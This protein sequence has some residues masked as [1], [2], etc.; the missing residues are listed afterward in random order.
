MTLTPAAN[1]VWNALALHHGDHPSIPEL[2]AMVGVTERTVQR[3]IS[4]LCEAGV[5]AVVARPGSVNEYVL[6]GVT[7]GGD[8]LNVRGDI[9]GDICPSE[10]PLPPA[11]TVLFTSTFLPLPSTSRE[12]A[13]LENQAVQ[14][15]DRLVT[16][17]HIHYRSYRK[18]QFELYP[19]ARTVWL[20]T[21]S[22]MLADDGRQLDEILTVLDYAFAQP[23]WR[24]K[25]RAVFDLRKHYDR[26]L[27][28]YRDLLGDLYSEEEF[29][30]A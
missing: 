10:D 11:A 6:S 7:S 3:A 1:K 23:S 26:L 9:G 16:L 28:E 12:K 22:I 8:I 24:P 17:R 4:K 15:V 14:I 25:I 20:K 29:H 2:A 21:A 30:G 18:R 5:L 19:K 27:A 13:D